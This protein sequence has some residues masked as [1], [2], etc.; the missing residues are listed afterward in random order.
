MS[1]PSCKERLDLQLD[2]YL[3]EAADKEHLERCPDCAAE[4]ALLRALA[5]DDGPGAAEPLDDLA[6]R[7]FI[8]DVLAGADELDGK[9]APARNVESPPRRFWTPLP[10]FAGA[11]LGACATAALF[12]LIVMPSV[13]A[14]VPTPPP[15][16]DRGEEAPTPPPPSLTPRLLLTAGVVRSGSDTLA[17]GDSIPLDQSLSVDDGH[18]LVELESGRLLHLADAT[19]ITFEAEA[20]GEGPRVSLARGALLASVAPRREGGRGLVVETSRGRVLV[21]GTVFSVTVADDDVLVDVL[22][23]QVELLRNDDMGPEPVEAGQRRSFVAEESSPLPGE[24]QEEMWRALRPADML[25]GDAGARLSIRSTPS[26]AMVR[27]DGVS[28]GVTPLVL[29]LRAGHRLM[30]LEAAGHQTAR[31]ALDIAP[32]LTLSRNITLEQA[33]DEAQPD[34]GSSR[35]ATSAESSGASATELLQQAQTLRAQRE[36]GAAA[37]AYRQLLQAHPNR[38]EARAALVSLGLIEL[39]QLGRPNAALQL[40]QRYLAGGGGPLA[41]EAQYGVARALRALGRASEERRALEQLLERYPGALQTRA[42]RRRLGALTG[43]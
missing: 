25:A 32:G 40:F 22:R 16:P 9:A 7:R 35:P 26:G 28:L 15:S 37:R 31:E 14:P 23:G 39:G 36:F 30:T 13:R 20:E 34:A 38:P 3:D 10:L 5:E 41:P 21:T 27:L 17:P 33:E 12:L 43:E 1:T 8:D 2:D 42:A 4:A 6:R 18:A 29:N 11:T 24:R 19:E